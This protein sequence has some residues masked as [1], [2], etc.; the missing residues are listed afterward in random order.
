MNKASLK[1]T[2]SWLSLITLTLLS[3]FLGE[4]MYNSSWLIAILMV[5]LVLKGQQ[6]V[7]VFMG[8]GGAPKRWRAIMLSYVLVLPG[9]IGAIYS[10]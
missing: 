10:F 1:I 8:L 6:V 9:L 2:L 7:D 5:I 3:A 4:D